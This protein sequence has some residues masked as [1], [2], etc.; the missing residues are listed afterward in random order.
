MKWLAIA[1]V[2]LIAALAAFP[3]TVGAV[4]ALISGH[5]DSARSIS[6]ISREIHA[7][8]ASRR[9]ARFQRKLNRLSSRQPY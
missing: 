8:D 5:V 2:V 6:Y 9:H 1:L 4:G 3:V 7:M